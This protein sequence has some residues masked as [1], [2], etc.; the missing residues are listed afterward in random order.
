MI[1][2][3]P[4]SGMAGAVMGSQGF[5]KVVG[6]RGASSAQGGRFY[7]LGGMGGLVNPD[8]RGDP[9]RSKV[10]SGRHH[11]PFRAMIL[12]R[13][14]GGPTCKTSMRLA[15]KSLSWAAADAFL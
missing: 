6:S 2:R 12:T 9:T 14:D 3:K 7:G 13:L 5:G 15:A 11:M 4:R 8:P 1:S 10:R